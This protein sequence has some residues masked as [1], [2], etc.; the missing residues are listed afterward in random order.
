MNFEEDVVYIFNTQAENNKSIHMFNRN[1][2]LGYI[3]DTKIPYMM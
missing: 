3:T 1:Y 2:D